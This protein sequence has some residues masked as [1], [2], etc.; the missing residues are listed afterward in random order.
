MAK[1][2]DR[3]FDATGTARPYVER[4][5][6]DEDVRK[7]LKNAFDTARAIYDELIGGRSAVALGT[8]VATDREL[9]DDLRGIIDDLRHA[10]ER[11]QGK[12]DHK[13]RNT[14]LLLTGI[15]LGVLFNPMTGPATRAWLRERLFGGSDD[16]TYTGSGNSGQSNTGQST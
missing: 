13:G 7:D 16:F 9:Q 14:T 15:A 2:T 3:I 10:T 12:H 5:L 8:R 4:A 11:I 1:T 6:R